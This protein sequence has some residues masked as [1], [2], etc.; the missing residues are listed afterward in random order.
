MKVL[1]ADKFEK[2]GIDGLKE[3]GCTVLSQP[4]V[5]ADGLAAADCVHGVRSHRRAPQHQDLRLGN[6]QP[7]ACRCR[8]HRRS[9]PVGQGRSV[10]RR[11]GEARRIAR[12]ER[13][14]GGV[15]HRIVGRF[16]LAG[17]LER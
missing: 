4:D 7:A 15:L 1:I 10:G 3:L 16:T 12:R 6:P 8:R 2:V 9:D 5:K 14:S 13:V 11:P 17:V